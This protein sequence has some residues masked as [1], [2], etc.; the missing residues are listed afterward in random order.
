MLENVIG[1]LWMV[2]MLY[3][4]FQNIGLRVINLTNAFKFMIILTKVVTLKGICSNRH[5]SE[6]KIC[7][8]EYTDVEAH[9]C[10]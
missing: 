1:K 2:I 4:L 9:K 5:C 6:I 10:M 7:F 8:Y 3:Q